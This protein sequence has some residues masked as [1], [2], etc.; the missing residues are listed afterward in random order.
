MY[1]CTDD[2]DKFVGRVGSFVAVK[3]KYGGKL[4][5]V[6]GNKRSAVT[7]T[8]DWFWNEANL[9]KNY[10]DRIDNDYY[11]KQCDDAIAAIEKYYPF[12]EFVECDPTDFMFIP[13]GTPDEIPFEQCMNPPAVA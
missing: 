6:K 13:E 10:P 8:K 1:I 9:M 7:G 11:R 2:K 4:M 12:K 3:K 5:R